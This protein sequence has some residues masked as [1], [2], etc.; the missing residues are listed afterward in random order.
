MQGIQSF[1]RKNRDTGN[2]YAVFGR[3]RRILH[4]RVYDSRNVIIFFCQRVCI[5]AVSLV[6]R[7]EVLILDR[8][9]HFVCA[10]DACFPG[11]SYN[12]SELVSP[13]VFLRIFRHV[14]VKCRGSD[15]EKMPAVAEYAVIC[16][17]RGPGSD[18][19]YRNIVYDKHYDCEN[20]ERRPPVRNDFI[21]LIGGRKLSG[22]FFLNAALDNRSDVNIAFVCDNAFRV[23]I[24]LCLRGFYVFF[25]VI[26]Y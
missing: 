22:A 4:R 21:D 16:P 12:G 20:R 25:D 13:D 18:G 10:Y 5:R 3:I 17:V 9:H 19:C 26:H 2:P 7:A 23:V 6:E 24:Q 8:T 1:F 11:I 15:S 14:F